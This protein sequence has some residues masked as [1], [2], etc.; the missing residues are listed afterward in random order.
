[1]NTLQKD[2]AAQSARYEALL[3]ITALIWGSA[4]VAQRIGMEHLGPFSYNGARFAIGFLSLIP[5]ILFRK[6]SKA[7][8]K[9]AIGPGLLAGLV[10]TI[11]ADLQQMGL[12]FTTAGKAGFIT[13]LYVVLVPIAA[14]ILGKRTPL[15]A[16]LGA[17]L[18][19]GGLFL[20][21]VSKD[22]S[23]T[24][25]DLLVLVSA[26]FWTAHILVLDRWAP[27]VDP[28]V[29]AATQFGLCSVISWGV[30]L[31]TE[32]MI[33][34]NFV[35]GAWPILYGGIMSIGIAYT[36]QAVAQTKAHPA[37]ASI[38]LALESAFAA[39][40]GWAILGEVLSAR[41][42]IGCGLM[43]LGMIVAQLPALRS[44]IAAAL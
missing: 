44:K 12:Q 26:L 31:P 9:A 36:L 42:F 41:E 43:L 21:S 24:K 7:A 20:L 37:R 2:A 40:F 28:I 39:L 35:G 30:A 11:A 13:G 8:V 25:G 15:K 19:L 38:I 6:T 29:L 34:A 10:L 18:A 27:K 1:M 4:F 5:L 14:M 33:L 22:L 16:W 23:M 3:L 17:A 32:P